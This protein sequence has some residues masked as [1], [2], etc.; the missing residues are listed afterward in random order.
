MVNYSLS[1]PN[2]L[3]H[4]I[5]NEVVMRY[6]HLLKGL[7][8]DLGCGTAPYKEE[9][10]EVAD[11]CIGLDWPQTL[12]GNR[13]IDVFADI[14]QRLPLRDATADAVV[15][16]QVMEHLSEPGNFIV[17]CNR[18]LKP[19][20]RIVITVPFMWYVHE[21]PHDYFRFTRYGLEHLLEKRGF[22]D[23]EIRETTGFWQMWVLKF[24]YHTIKFARGPLKFAWIPIWWLGQ[25]VSPLMDKVDRHPEETASYV[26]LARKVS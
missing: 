8:V 17:E 22:E 16:F 10:L 3:I 24:N 21:A 26:V 13:G 20:G 12:H 4:K 23:I 9:I 6:R 11:S 18:I 14:Q 7:V 5:N 2:W 15:S 1:Q 19:G 25:A